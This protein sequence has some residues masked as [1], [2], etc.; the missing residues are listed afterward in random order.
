MWQTC[1]LAL[2]MRISRWEDLISKHEAKDK[3]LAATVTKPANLLYNSLMNFSGAGR[4]FVGFKQRLSG[5]FQFY[6]MQSYTHQ[7]LA[8]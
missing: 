6:F 3:Q 7:L 4:N 2:F 1:L 5:Y 8:V